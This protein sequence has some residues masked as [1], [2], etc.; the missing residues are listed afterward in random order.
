MKFNI[1][2]K[3]KNCQARVGTITT[4]RGILETPF[5]MPVGTV[6][7]VKAVH[8]RELEQD[9]KTEIIL[10]NAYHLYLRPGLDILMQA[11][12][13]HKFINWKG[14]I[15]TD[16]GGYQVYSLATNRKITEEGV[17]FQSHIDGAKH[18]IS[19]ESSIDMQR[20]I[21]ADF[22]MAFDECTPYPCEHE[23]A[24]KSMQLTHRWLSRNLKRLKESDHKYDYPQNFFPIVQGSTFQDLRKISAEFI[25]QQDCAGNAI[26]GLSVGEPAEIMY[27]ITN[28]VCNILPQNKPRY[29]MG[30]GTPAN[31]LESVA[32]GIDMFDCVIPT[33]NARHGLLYTPEGIINIKNEKWKNDF[34]P[35]NEIPLSFVDQYYSRAYI[36]HLIYSNEILG[37][38]VTS[39]SNLAF[40][41][42]LMQQI[43][44][45][46]KTGD[47]SEWKTQMTE[48]ISR[49]L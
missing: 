12:G 31:I 28:E 35:V 39:V 14:H 7:T 32:L 4:E 49:R 38:Q 16:S 23:Y 1:V 5:F 27:D 15:L 37:F 2:V 20:N 3:D 29:L 34:S 43:R 45:H 6:G 21:G 33:R 13:I 41:I 42:W 44:E 30:V 36:R 18:F 11:G 48:K 17:S 9:I 26:G 46:I 10:S 40:Y 8:Q 25:S 47:F 24:E 22:I 19:P